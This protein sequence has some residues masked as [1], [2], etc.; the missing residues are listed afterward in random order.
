MEHWKVTLPFFVLF[1][2]LL[3]PPNPDSIKEKK[4]IHM[5]KK[6]QTNLKQIEHF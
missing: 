5:V 2:Q 3:V 6:P 4:K 1:L